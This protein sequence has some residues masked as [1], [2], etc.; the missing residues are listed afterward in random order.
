M[1]EGVVDRAETV[2]VD[3]DEGGTGA[4]ALGVVQRGPGALQQPLAVGQAGEWV[5][6]LLLGAGAGDPQGGVQGDQR[7]GEHR[8]QERRV[9]G[10][11][12][13]QR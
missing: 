10:G 11:H 8:Q 7:Y 3:Q 1:S 9:H 13:D 12:H 2:Q 4:D 6:Q 5:P